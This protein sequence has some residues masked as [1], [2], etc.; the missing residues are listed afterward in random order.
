M[1][2]ILLG[3]H[4]LN[5]NHIFNKYSNEMI[6]YDRYMLDIKSYEILYKVICL[7][8]NHKNNYIINYK[9]T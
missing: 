9:S 5:Y 2:E 8:N 7:F 6:L 1:Y 4:N 3:N